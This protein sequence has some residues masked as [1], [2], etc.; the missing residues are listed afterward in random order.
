MA[1][2]EALVV[3]DTAFKGMTQQ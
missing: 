1:V 2:V 3:G